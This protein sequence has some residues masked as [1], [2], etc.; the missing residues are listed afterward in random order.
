MFV[1]II[2]DCRD[3]NAFGRQA[4]RA[5][6]LFNSPVTT[7][8][9]EQDELEASG[10]LVDMLD[11]SEG[12]EGVILVNVA[13]RHGRGKKWPNGTPFGYFT[14]KKTLVVASVD[15]VTLSLVKKLGLLKE[16]N[17][18][19][20]PTVTSTLV[21]SGDLTNDEKNH[22]VHTQFRS[23]DFLPR[24]ANWLK[25]GKDLPSTDYPL[26]NIPDVPKAVW[27]V[28][29]FGNC[30]TTLFADD[31]LF[32]AGK[33]IT[34]AVGELTCYNRLKDVPNGESG[35]II[36]SSGYGENRF[37]E[38]VSQGQSAAKHFELKVGSPLF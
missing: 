21:E 10:N 20:I 5:M 23:Y 30:K 33:R 25:E 19:D 9:I 13:P 29:N 17:L 26:E 8:G 16:F 28:D 31:I 11:A 7:V 15:G 24:V 34:T 1:T 37:L 27:F 3:Q 4:T 2:N 6:A 14:L 38:V 22:I 18:F 12:E 35:L 32:S 36:G